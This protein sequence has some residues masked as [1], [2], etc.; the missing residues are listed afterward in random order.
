MQD[1]FDKIMIKYHRFLIKHYSDNEQLQKYLDKQIYP[2]IKN[3][4][5]Q[6]VV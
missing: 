1:F 4:L 2:V 5:M 3:A 6:L